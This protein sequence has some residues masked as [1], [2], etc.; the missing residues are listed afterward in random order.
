MNRMIVTFYLERKNSKDCGHT[1]NERPWKEVQKGPP[2]KS[3]PHTPQPK[4]KLPFIGPQAHQNNLFKPGHP[5]HYSDYPYY[6]DPDPDP[7]PEV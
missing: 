7:T 6:S 1:K 4:P 3:N 2:H 5:F